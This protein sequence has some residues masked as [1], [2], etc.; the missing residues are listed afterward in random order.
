M[1]E[2]VLPKGIEVVLFGLSVFEHE[3]IARRVRDALTRRE[4]ECS[5]HPTH[6]HTLG[7]AIKIVS[8]RQ[9]NRVDIV[10]ISKPTD[11][12]LINLST[13]CERLAAALAATAND[14]WIVFGTP[15]LNFLSAVFMRSASVHNGSLEDVVQRRWERLTKPAARIA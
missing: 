8:Q 2:F 15:D 10:H 3:N 9:A 4:C 1:T 6:V 12:S 13:G 7:D 5:Y 14:A 11:L